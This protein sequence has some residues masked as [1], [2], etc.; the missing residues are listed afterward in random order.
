MN[1]NNEWKEKLDNILEKE[2]AFEKL[3]QANINFYRFCNLLK[4]QQHDSEKCKTDAHFIIQHPNPNKSGMK[5]RCVTC[6]QERHHAK[7]FKKYL[8]LPCLSEKQIIELKQEYNDPEI[9]IKKVLAMFF[10]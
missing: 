4:K 3:Y 1:E 6:D 9:S 7:N 5:W 8:I 10:E 2:S